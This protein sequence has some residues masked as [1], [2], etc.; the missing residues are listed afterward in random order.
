MRNVKLKRIMIRKYTIFIVTYLLFFPSC[1]AVDA[2][3]LCFNL[4]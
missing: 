3:V 4:K 2:T 1:C